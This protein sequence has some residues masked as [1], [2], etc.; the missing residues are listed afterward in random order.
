VQTD[1]NFANVL[2]DEPTGT[3]NLIDFGA[4]RE[5]NPDFV[6]GWPTIPYTFLN[7]GQWARQLHNVQCLHKC[8]STCLAIKQSM[9]TEMHYVVTSLSAKFTGEF[10]T[11]DMS[12]VFGNA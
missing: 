9:S 6:S 2:Y 10:G 5:F 3:L 8:F 11:T 4:S 1:P 12:S 7:T